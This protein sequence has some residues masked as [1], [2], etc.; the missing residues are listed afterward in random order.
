ML[1]NA[2]KAHR[3]C[4]CVPTFQIKRAYVYAVYMRLKVPQDVAGNERLG[5]KADGQLIALDAGVGTDQTHCR[6]KKC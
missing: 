6:Q 3:G 2:Q 1:E 4:N 5:H